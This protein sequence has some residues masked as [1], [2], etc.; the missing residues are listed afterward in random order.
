MVLT[1]LKLVVHIKALLS[2]LIFPRLSKLLPHRRQCN[3]FPFFLLSGAQ[4]RITNNNNNNDNNN[5]PETRKYWVDVQRD[6]VLS[7]GERDPL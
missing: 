1:A 5:Y 7:H 3:L 2:M 6:I 4:Y